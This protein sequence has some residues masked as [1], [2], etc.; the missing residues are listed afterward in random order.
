M[1]EVSQ[2]LS[3]SGWSEGPGLGPGPGD[4]YDSFKN[5]KPIH[6][7][8]PVLESIATTA[9]ATASAA[10]TGGSNNANAN[11]TVIDYE[12]RY[13]QVMMRY[14]QDRAAGSGSY[15]YPSA[16]NSTNTNTTA[17]NDT[18]TIVSDA[19]SIANSNASDGKNANGILGLWRRGKQNLAERRKRTNPSSSVTT[20]FSTSTSVTTSANAN[21][22]H[23]SNAKAGEVA[24]QAA[25]LAKHLVHDANYRDINKIGSTTTTSA[26]ASDATDAKRV[27]IG[28]GTDGGTITNSTSSPAVSADEYGDLRLGTLLIPLSNLPLEETIPRVEKWYQFDTL[29]NGTRS[30]NGDNA[31]AGVGAANANANATANAKGATSPRGTG[32]TSSG[33]S[34]MGGDG[35]NLAPWRD[36]TVLLVRAAC[37]METCIGLVVYWFLMVVYES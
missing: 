34:G 35:N 37:S 15:T 24:N 7:L 31:V 21:I 11:A 22:N 2:S 10:A 28:I 26:S 32:G 30:G 9:T 3:S 23:K 29:G 4:K 12:N 14:A 20:S 33:G 16:P 1:S 36:P 13:E 27:G 5:T 19:E 8:E 6:Q 17:G 18:S 25:V